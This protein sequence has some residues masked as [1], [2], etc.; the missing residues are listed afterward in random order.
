MT[1][2]V[3]R[4]EGPLGSTAM[5][6]PIDSIDRV[7]LRRSCFWSELTI[8]VVNGTQRSIGGLAERNAVRVR[9]A[10]FWEADRIAKCWRRHLKGLASLLSGALYIRYSDSR[11]IHKTVVDAV[12]Q[13]G[14]LVLDRL[15]QA[16]SEVLDR[17]TPLQSIEVFE[18]RRKRLNGMYVK[19][20]VR[21]VKTAAGKDLT[22]EQ[23]E[24]IANDE[25]VTLVLAG[26]GTGKTK[27]IVGKVAHLIRNQGVKP[28]NIL[29]L[30]YNTDAAAEIRER[31]PD[32]LSGTHVYTF[33]AFGN[34]VVA[35]CEGKKRTISKLAE[36]EHQFRNYIYEILIA[37]LLDPLQKKAVKDFISRNGYVYQSPFD[38]KTPAEYRQYVRNIELRSLSGDPVKSHAELA[39]ANYLTAYGI[40]VAY[41]G[42]YEVDTATAQRRQYRPD[43]FLPEYNIYIEHFALDQKGRPPSSWQRYAQDVKWKRDLHRECG[44]TLIETYSWQYSKGILL[45]TLRANLEEMGIKFVRVPDET[46]IKKLKEH[47]PFSRLAKLLITFLDHVKTGNLEDNDLRSRA[48]KMEDSQRSMVFLDVFEQV[49]MRYEDRLSEDK[50]I[51]FN[52]QINLAANHI[53]QDRWESPYRYVLVDEFQDISSGRIRLLQ[54]LRRRNVAYFLVGDDWQSIYRFAGSDVELFRNCSAYLGYVQERML[55]KT[56]RFK[57]G[58]LGPSTKFI[59]RNPEQTKRPLKSESSAD[60]EGITVFAYGNHEGLQRALQDIEKKSQGKRPHTSVM[61]MG[62]YN[63]TLNALLKGQLIRSFKSLHMEFTTVHRAKGREADYVVVIDLKDDRWGFPSKVEDDPLLEIV[64]PPVFETA[65]P[66]AEERRLFYVAITRAKIGAY[67]VT[68]AE[69]PSAFVEELQKYDHL[70][71]VGAFAPKCPRCDV[72]VLVVR[73]GPFSLFM[74]CTEYGSE[75]SCRYT[76][77]IDIDPDALFDG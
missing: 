73:K 56:F 63:H 52:D 11:E 68:D 10:I 39:I 77:D 71:Q 53:H 22:Y 43:F 25:D 60:N 15:D 2:D 30:A 51:D 66:F 55:S 4:M 6:I 49:R 42:P 16:A 37:L 48:N 9:D 64:L 62:R 50:G 75:P 38:F 29:V 69:H 41:E 31:L 34:S 67:L 26:A 19:R 32:D 72:G 70:L 12:R 27:V 59:Q 57:D 33:H 17:L 14:K 46:L 7:T 40:E 35:K 36:D 45:R 8:Y 13:R 5:E 44:S 18:A 76:K 23:A 24:A 20:C 65:Y 54:V 47:L 58:I 28:S 61:V 74:G 3:V 1:S 21:P